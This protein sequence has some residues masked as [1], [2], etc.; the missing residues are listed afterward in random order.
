MGCKSSGFELRHYYPSGGSSGGSV[1][2]EWEAVFSV[3][4]LDQVP[5][6]LSLS[7]WWWHWPITT[8][9]STDCQRCPGPSLTQGY[10]AAMHY[11]WYAN[12][13]TLD[14][15]WNPTLQATTI[16]WC[17]IST[18]HTR[19]PKHWNIGADTHT[20]KIIAKTT[21]NFTLAWTP[22]RWN[23]EVSYKLTLPLREAGSSEVGYW[24]ALTPC[25]SPEES[26]EQTV[27]C[28]WTAYK[29][30]MS[31]HQLWKGFT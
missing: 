22:L 16:S 24:M 26:P 14:H 15:L 18:H 1:S 11:G 5:L 4:C 27:E 19:G 12:C 8:L 3:P 30:G 21:E 2:A 7:H 31:I 9:R 23:Q 10:P 17:L 25:P 13:L 6:S 20:H 29:A 28:L